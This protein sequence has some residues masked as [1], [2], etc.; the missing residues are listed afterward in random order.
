[1]FDAMNLF[2]D[3]SG[4]IFTKRSDTPRTV[5]AYRYCL[6]V[7]IGEQDGSVTVKPDVFIE[8]YV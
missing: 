5:T 3:Y 4:R 6:I 1:M 2:Y 7:G 8:D